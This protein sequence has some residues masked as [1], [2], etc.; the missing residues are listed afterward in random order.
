MFQSKLDLYQERHKEF[1]CISKNSLEGKISSI[2]VY[3]FFLEQQGH[4]EL[5]Q[6]SYQA[7][8]EGITLFAA[9]YNGG[10][11][12]TLGTIRQSFLNRIGETAADFSAAVPQKIS[13]RHRVQ[14]GFTNDEV[15]GILGAV[16]RDAAIG[17]RDYAMILIMAKAEFRSVDIT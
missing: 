7:I 1:Y 14:Y 4:K 8:N 16:N 15:T 9:F 13:K 3:L 6:F 10:L 5:Y 12:R 17:K 11:L 2:R